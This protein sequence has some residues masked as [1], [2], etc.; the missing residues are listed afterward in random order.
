MNDAPLTADVVRRLRLAYA[1]SP[2]RA[3]GEPCDDPE[4]I[5]EAV[6]G[7]LEPAEV[8]R[9]LDH[10]ARC[11][12]CDRAFQLARELDR[13]LAAPHP[14]IRFRG[15]PRPRRSRML[16]GALLVSAAAAAA[17]LVLR[18]EPPPTGP[19]LREVSGRAIISMPGT[20]HLPRDGV[21]LRWAGGPK[22]T[23]YELWVTTPALREVY[24]ASKLASPEAQV[25][26]SALEGLPVGAEILWRVEAR[27]PDG[28]RGVS[29]AFRTRLE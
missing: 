17:L 15:R 20:D 28:G 25:P 23:V 4:R 19:V 2:G 13:Q 12:G 29:P 22:G 10:A 16:A 8:G 6:Q 7:K 27:F 1:A 11:T 9:L 14:D 26:L 5:W 24:Q 21:V 18:R 3:T